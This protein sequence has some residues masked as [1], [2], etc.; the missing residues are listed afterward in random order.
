M[1]WGG[2]EGW[3]H[4][5]C[6]ATTASDGGIM[7]YDDMHRSLVAFEQDSTLVAVIEM[8]QSSWLVAGLVPGLSRDPE[9]TVEP[10]PEGLLAVL[11]RWQREAE[12]AGRPIGRIAVA[13]EAGR[14]GFW[15][16]RWLR[17]RGIEPHVLHSTSLPVSRSHRRTKS[18]RLDPDLL[19]QSFVGWRRG[20]WE[21]TRMNPR[22]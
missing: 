9:K 17:A 2:G 19:I 21:D 7:A 13:Y 12:R 18:D 22:P 6:L 11:R 10:D 20:H 14:D 1:L 3:H 16:A 8:S 15:L 4:R 5:R